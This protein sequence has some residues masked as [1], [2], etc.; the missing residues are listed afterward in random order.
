MPTRSRPGTGRRPPRPCHGGARRSAAAPR[1]TVGR[2]RRSP[3]RRAR[4]GPRRRRGARRLRIAPRA[5]SCR[6]PARRSRSP[7][8][9]RHPSVCQ[10]SSSRRSAA[11]RPTNGASSTRA[12]TTGSGTASGATPTDP[13]ALA[14]AAASPPGP[15]SASTLVRRAWPPESSSGLERVLP[16]RPSIPTRAYTRTSTED[17]RV[18]SVTR[19]RHEPR[20]G[21]SLDVTSGLEWRRD[22]VCPGVQASDP[23]AKAKEACLVRPVGLVLAAALRIAPGATRADDPRSP[24]GRSYFPA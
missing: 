15:A 5:A 23:E 24:A 13:I 8:R 6:C 4:R 19:R 14:S 1:R 20:N 10:R 16:D 2:A 21:A 9:R 18:R 22:R 12:S 3:R 11:V 17:A 7:G